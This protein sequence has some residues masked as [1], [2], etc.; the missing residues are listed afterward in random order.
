MKMKEVKGVSVCDG[1]WMEKREENIWEESKIV[2]YVVFS[3]Q[4]IP[5]SGKSALN[6]NFVH[7]KKRRSRERLFHITLLMV[8]LQH[9]SL[10]SVY[11]WDYELEKSRM[12][13]LHFATIFTILY[14]ITFTH[15]CIK[16]IFLQCNCIKWRAFAQSRGKKLWLSAF[17]VW[18]H[19]QKGKLS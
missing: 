8:L 3:V 15:M 17:I 19:C 16:G 5:T 11:I 2:P 6:Q 4:F 14:L 13:K 9:F 1:G 12:M 7:Q 18:V 10:Y